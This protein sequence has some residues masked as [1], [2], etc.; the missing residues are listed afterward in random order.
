MNTRKSMNKIKKARIKKNHE[1]KKEKKKI[2][3]L[4]KKTKYLLTT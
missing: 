2:W 4:F 3:N 1:Y